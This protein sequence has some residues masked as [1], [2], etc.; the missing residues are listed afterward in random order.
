LYLISLGLDKHRFMG[1]MAWFFLIINC[2]K[3]PLFVLT[4]MI[5]LPSLQL[6]LHFLPGIV[7]G[8]LLGRFLFTR[9]PQK[10]FQ[11]TVQLLAAAAALRLI[12]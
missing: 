1:S 10:P 9:I 2:L 8:A 12:F 4:G 3:I 6:S 5:T 11:L 7:I